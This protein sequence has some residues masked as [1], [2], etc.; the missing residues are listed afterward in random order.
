M[1]TLPPGDYTGRIPMPLIDSL[2]DTGMRQEA[3]LLG[4][5]GNIPLPILLLGVSQR[6]CGVFCR[7]R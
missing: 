2:R 4:G 1:C 3:P 6:P 7:Y 5:E